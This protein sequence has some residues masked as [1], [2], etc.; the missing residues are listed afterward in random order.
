MNLFAVPLAAGLP[1]LMGCDLE[2]L[3]HTGIPSGPGTRPEGMCRGKQTLNLVSN[4]C[5]PTVYQT[6]FVAVALPERRNMC[7]K[8]ELM[9]SWA[10]NL[11]QSPTMLRARSS[12]AGA[13]AIF[14]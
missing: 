12:G 9:A 3:E 7:R 4:K 11:L 13:V 2:K 14:Y 8:N 5:Q 10:Y 1:G 6:S